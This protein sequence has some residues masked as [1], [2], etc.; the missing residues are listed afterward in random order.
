MY[1][2]VPVL[3]RDGVRLYWVRSIITDRKVL[4]N[5]P[6]IVIMDRAQS[7]VFLVDITIPNLVRAETEK[8]LRVSNPRPWL[9]KQGC[10]QLRQ[11]AVKA[12]GVPWQLTSSQDAESGVAG[13]G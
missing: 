3:E 13:L 5:K 4:A 2:P 7:R 11:S 12:T 9:R 6:D 1:T 8:N 10:C